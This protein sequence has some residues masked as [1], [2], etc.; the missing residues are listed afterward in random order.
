MGI[1]G[2]SGVGSGAEVVGVG[3]GLDG[4]CVRRGLSN[5]RSGLT[6]GA[7][8]TAVWRGLGSTGGFAFGW[9]GRLV[10]G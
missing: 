1:V 3:G 7:A 5:V 4:G 8:F 2:V 9:R 10:R 6:L